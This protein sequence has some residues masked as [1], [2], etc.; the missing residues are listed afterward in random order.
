MAV[1]VQRMVVP[2][3]AGV[4]F[5]A[6]P[7]TRQPDGR[8]RGG[9]LR[10]RRGPGLGPRE[11]GRLH[12]A[13]RRGHRQGHR[14]QAASPWRLA[15]PAARGERAI[16]PERQ[17]QPALTDA[18]VVRLVRARPADRGALRPPPGH[19]VVPGGRRL[20]DRPEPADHHAVPH[21]RG[22]RP[23]EPRL[24]VRRSP[25]DDDRRH[26][27]AGALLV[28]ADDAAADGRGRR[29]AVRRRHPASWRRRRAAPASSRPAAKSDPLIRDALETVLA[30]RRLRPAAPGRGPRL[31]RRPATVPPPLDADPAIV[32]EL[33]GRTEASIAAL[34]RD[35]RTKSGPELL[36]F[37]LA[38]LQELRRLL[39]DPLSHRVFM[40]AME[41][42]W[43]LNEHLEAWL[44]EKNAAD[45]LTQSVP[46]NVTSE[47][48]LALLDVADAIRPHPEVVA[49]LERV[50]GRGLP[51]R[52]A[53]ARGRAEARDAIRAWL[54]EYGMRCV[55]EIDITRPRWSE[56]PV[57][58]PAPR[59]WATSGASRRA[60]PGGASS[61]DGAR[62]RKKE[63]ELLERLRALPDGDRKAERDEADDRPGPDLHRVPG[64]S[65]VR[66][67]QPL[68]RVQAGA[69][70]G[71]RATGGGPRARR[72]RRTSSTSRFDELHD[73]VRTR[74]RG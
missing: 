67:G 59:S 22:R 8:L 71:S 61:K 31:G 17:R 29:A 12:G 38:D 9:Q 45:T 2:H 46:H 13:R 57:H 60:R 44:G 48:G 6:D 66:H 42:T 15:G 16:E 55:G 52:A 39:F 50:E 11:R 4:L 3:A 40:A 21:P 37:I 49:F 5:T 30:S 10:P 54:D 27:A 56:R 53:G 70:G 18:Q 33:I 47:M 73:V 20:P 58:A 7:V 24:S 62:P 1:V 32:T 41:A 34:K 26:E 43:W 36:D 65:E 64:V 14:Q 69:A 74:P 68:L 35:I 72:P 28:A 63:Q 23:G 19:R 25:A 51:G